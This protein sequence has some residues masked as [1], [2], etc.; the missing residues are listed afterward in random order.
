MASS[1]WKRFAFFDRQSLNLASEVLEDLIPI[2]GSEGRTSRAALNQ[3]AEAANDSVSLVVSTVALPLKSKPSS[4]LVKND[5]EELPLTDMWSSLNAC[6]APGLEGINDGESIRLPSQAQYFEDDSNMVN[7]ESAVDGLVLIF[8][9][10]RDTDYVHCFDLTVRCNPP[11]ASSKDNLEDMDGWRGYFAPFKTKRRPVMMPAGAT[12]EDRVVSEHLQQDTTEGIVHIAS[13]RTASG[14]RPLHMACITK[15]NVLVCVDPHLYLSWYVEPTFCRGRMGDACILTLS[16]HTLF[17]DSFVDSRRPLATPDKLEGPTF[18]LGSE[19]NVAKDGNAVV[20]DIVPGIVAVGT[21]KGSVHTFTYGGGR[22][23]LRPYLSIPAPPTSGMVVTTCKL[24]VTEEKVSIFVGYRRT[25]ITSSPRGANAGV[26]C[27]DMPLPGP[28]P[29]SISAPS[30]RHD[31]D[32]R[33]VFSTAL[34]DAAPSTDGVMLTVARPDGLYTYSTT[35]K[36][37]VSPIDGSKLAMCVVPPPENAGLGREPAV[38]KAG[39]SFALVASTDLKSR[40]DAVDIYDSN[41]K[42]VAFHLLLS[43]G[44]TA[45]RAAGVT[46]SP[47]RSADGTLRNGRSSAVIFTSGGSLVSLTEKKTVEKVH[48]LVQKNLFSAAIYIAYG[49]PSYEP[50]EIIALYRKHAE[51]LYRKGDYSGAIEQYIHTIG[52]L[53]PSHVIFRYLDAPKIPLLV[54]VRHPFRS[55]SKPF[56]PALTFAFCS[57]WKN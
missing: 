14:H 37:D 34:C 11:D 40:R 35:Q 46:T 1:R 41:N 52:A 31:L 27:Y 33:Q 56:F 2:E 21:D 50:A 38:G 47:T 22:H 45:V 39:P 16:F 4:G 54:K 43:P 5:G 7:T 26:C 3:A 55:V 15:K 24:S 48:L 53:E 12:L 18:V 28:N 17:D 49:D 42:L 36:V 51:Y 6:S 29:S 32:G 13:C 25:S 20:V 19:W 23:V 57:I 8:L 9:T 30:A 10:S 44:H